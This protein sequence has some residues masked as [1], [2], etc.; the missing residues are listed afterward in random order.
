MTGRGGFLLMS[1]V[2]GFG[3]RGV[4]SLKSERRAVGCGE[5]RTAPVQPYGLEAKFDKGK[6]EG[7]IEIALK[8][9]QKGMDVAEIME[10]TGLSREDVESVH[11]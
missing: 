3:L 8:M 9:R 10:M 4:A 2:S 5:E 1:G 11:V 6:A 7:K